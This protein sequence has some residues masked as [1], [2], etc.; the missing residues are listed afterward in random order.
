MLPAP[1]SMVHS[2]RHLMT[3]QPKLMTSPRH[4]LRSISQPH[5]TN[6]PGLSQSLPAMPNVQPNLSRSDTLIRTF[7]SYTKELETYIF[8]HRAPP[9]DIQYW[10]YGPYWPQD[11]G[12]DEHE[13][14]WQRILLETPKHIR[15]NPRY[16][17]P[18]WNSIQDGKSSV[19][20]S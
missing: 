4:T 12:D 11:L 9:P 17:E 5:G 18:L 20:P 6:K 16:V 10:P 8:K 13:E 19:H 2:P 1:H 14:N 3:S 7:V 15:T